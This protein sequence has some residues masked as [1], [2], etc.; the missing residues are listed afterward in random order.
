MWPINDHEHIKYII[1]ETNERTEIIHDAIY[2][3]LFQII[4]LNSAANTKKWKLAS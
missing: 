4:K 1:S 2:V 3:M